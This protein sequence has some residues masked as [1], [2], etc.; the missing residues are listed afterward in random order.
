V[1]TKI[2]YIY[3]FRKI[4]PNRRVY[5]SSNVQFENDKKFKNYNNF[6]NEKIVKAHLECDKSEKLSKKYIVLISN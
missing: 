4:A 1:L 6:I 3:I 5:F 2:N